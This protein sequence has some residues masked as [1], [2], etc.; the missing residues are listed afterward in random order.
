MCATFGIA[1]TLVLLQILFFPNAVKYRAVHINSPRLLRNLVLPNR[2]NDWYVRG[3]ARCMHEN[4]PKSRPFIPLPLA[5][6]WSV[7]AQHLALAACICNFVF[8]LE[9][10]KI[11][12][13]YI[14][15]FHS[16]IAACLW[17]PG[18]MPSCMHL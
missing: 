12:Q 9:K 17:L 3:L 1:G 18:P 10:C 15:N 16:F 2:Q 5:V 14:C 11:I 13:L 8:G 6:Y 4:V 7:P